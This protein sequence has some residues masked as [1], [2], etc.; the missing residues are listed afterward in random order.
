[1]AGALRLGGFYSMKTILI[2]GAAGFIGGHACALFQRQGWRV[3][4]TDRKEPVWPA[5]DSFHR[6]DLLDREGL[7]ALARQINPAVILHLGAATRVAGLRWEDYGV[8][9]AGVD[10]VIAAVET[11]SACER[12]IF[13]STR[14]IC[15]VYSPSTHLW[16]YRP[17]NLYGLSKV[18]GEKLVRQSCLRVP[19]I[20]VRPTGIWGP[21]FRSPSYRDFFV[22]VQRGLYFHIRG[23]TPTRTFG[24]V[25]NAAYQM[26]RLAEAP[27]EQVAG[28][29]HYLGDYQPLQVRV[30]AELIAQQFG[31]PPVRELP[32]SAA[33]A[34][35]MVGDLLGRVGLNQLPLNSSRYHNMTADS[36]YDLS[37][38]AQ[39]APDLPHTL[40]TGTEL[41]TRWMRDG[42]K[43]RPF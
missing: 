31:R 28:S 19:W 5:G 40:E 6:C 30:W 32:R 22:Q 17:P 41:T 37:A 21:G 10:N 15:P 29:V 1:M 16:D 23:I 39:V 9:V 7:R 25:G 14:L 12:V 27:L 3:V 20:I 42:E 33:R 43:S 35:A 38:L 8:N 34:A 24:Y 13:A 4:G 18:E 36:V 26:L 11:A 2:T